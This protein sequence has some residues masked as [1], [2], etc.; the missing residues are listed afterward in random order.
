ARSMVRM[1]PVSSAAGPEV[2]IG[3]GSAGSDAEAGGL[4]AAGESCGGFAAGESYAGLGA[5]S[6]ATA[7][8]SA[9]GAPPAAAGLADAA[10]GFADAGDARR[11]LAFN[12]PNAKGTS[13]IFRVTVGLP[14]AG[15]SYG[16]SC[17]GCNGSGFLVRRLPAADNGQRGRL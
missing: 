1:P 2:S 14:P 7:A 13:P 8:R 3:A 15:P 4:A 12:L 11:N 16:G 10:G 5:R 9:A 6:P 17:G